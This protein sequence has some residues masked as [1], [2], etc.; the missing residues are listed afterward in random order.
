MRTR[1]KVAH[2]RSTPGSALG[3]SAPT[4]VD[5]ETIV[6]LIGIVRTTPGLTVKAKLDTR[7]YPAGIEV[8]NDK[9]RPQHYPRSL[10]RNWN[11]SCG[12]SVRR[13]A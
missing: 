7:T 13:A 6:Q 8:P 9:K 4:G 12:P 11:Y 5:H 1:R 2:H 3:A 10:P